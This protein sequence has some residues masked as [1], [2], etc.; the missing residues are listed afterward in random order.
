MQANLNEVLDQLVQ[1]KHQVPRLVSAM[2]EMGGDHDLNS[3]ES[4]YTI[5]TVS[6]CYH[7]RCDSGPDSLQ[8]GESLV[9]NHRV[10]L[11]TSEHNFN[12]SLL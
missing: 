1:P 3:R 12:Q 5:P 7:L 11:D 2:T 6:I 4:P 10:Y 8:R 9:T